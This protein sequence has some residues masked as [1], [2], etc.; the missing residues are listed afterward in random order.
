MSQPLKVLFILPNLEGGGAERVAL[1]LLRFLDR[2]KV[3]PA[4]YLLKRSGVY[5]NE[6]PDDID[7]YYASSERQ[8]IRQNL[9]VAFSNLSR[10]VKS[11]DVIIGAL[12]LDATYFAYV[13]ARLYD[14]PIIGWVHTLIQPY[15]STVNKRHRALVKMIYP[16]LDRVIFPS[17]KSADSMLKFTR[18]ER[19]KCQVVPNPLDLKKLY[20]LSVEELPSWALKLYEKPILISVGRLEFE[21]GIDWLIRAHKILLSKGLDNNLLILGEGRDRSAFEQL[22]KSLGV[23]NSVYMPGFISNPYPL[24]Q[25]AKIYFHGSL[26]EGFGLAIAEAQAL[27]IPIIAFGNDTE[28]PILEGS[29]ENIHLSETSDDDLVSRITELIEPSDRKKNMIHRGLSRVENLMPDKIAHE[30][31]TVFDEMSYEI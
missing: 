3:Q 22:V 16:R 19:S 1:T 5:W 11:S 6:V 21:K 9:G 7:I 2:K 12:E 28:S 26:Y 15:L 14:K 31:E 23:D 17:D 29:I 25:R 27:G 18:L 30:W 8:R 4:L 20:Q 13:W 10:L 24:I